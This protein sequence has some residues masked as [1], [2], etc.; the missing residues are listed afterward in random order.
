MAAAQRKQAS[1]RATRDGHAVRFAAGFHLVVDAVQAVL[2]LVSDR[3]DV[4]GLALLAAC[5][6][7][8]RGSR[9]VVPGS[10]DQQPAGER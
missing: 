7:G 4:I 10:L 6:V 8:R 5:R 2:G 1:S 9:P 3:E